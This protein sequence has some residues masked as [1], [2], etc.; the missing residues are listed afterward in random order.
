MTITRFVSIAVIASF[1]MA[2]LPKAVWAAEEG[3]SSVSVDLRAAIDRAAA[4]FLTESREPSTSLPTSRPV[5]NARQSAG[6]GGG[7]G[8][9][10]MIWTVVGT[11][12]SLAAT[13]FVIKEVRKQTDKAIRQQQ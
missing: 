7:R 3:S 4:Q 6:G 5:V 9:G 12:T 10:M 1:L 11:V 13:Y 2:A 8:T